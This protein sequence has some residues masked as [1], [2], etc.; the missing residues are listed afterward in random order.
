CVCVCVCVCLWVLYVCVCFGCLIELSLYGSSLSGW[1]PLIGFSLALI[2]FETG[3]GRSIQTL[4]GLTSAEWCVWSVC[5]VCGVCV[6][7]V[8]RV[9]SVC[10]VYINVSRPSLLRHTE[11]VLH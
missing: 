8:E 7:C 6:E 5:G 3:V 10:R 1:C 9:W 4:M 11:S 2:C